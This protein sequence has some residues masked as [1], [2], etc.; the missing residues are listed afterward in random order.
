MTPKY[1][2][3]MRQ[4][5][6]AKTRLA[7][8]GCLLWTASTDASGYGHMVVER[9]LRR[10]THV[11]WFMAT[12]EWPVQDVLHTC[13][14]PG[15]VEH[16]HHFQGSAADNAA[17]RQRKGRG[18]RGER[19]GKRRLTDDDVRAI[20]AAAGTCRAIAS[21]YGTDSGTVSRIQRRVVWS[22]VPDLD[23]ADD[24]L[25]FM[26]TKPRPTLVGATCD[27]V[28]ER[29]D[30]RR[31]RAQG[32]PPVAA[33][34]TVQRCGRPI[35]G[36]GEISGVPHGMCSR[37]FYNAQMFHGGAYLVFQANAAAENLRDMSNALRRL[38]VGAEQATQPVPVFDPYEWEQRAEWDE[39]A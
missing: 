1:E 25:L 30:V 14:T 19:N 29:V 26:L 12:G 11:A 9:R 21:Q 24:M 7:E 4:R 36:N 23:P 5:F 32:T 33:R 16:G 20:R 34:G 37:C 27:M 18:Q 39:A 15:C 38:N 35:W 2:T 6:A 10:A 31:W 8:N 28:V 3:K 22:R 17:D 13:D